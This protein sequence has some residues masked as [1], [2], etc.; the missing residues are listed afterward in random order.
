MMTMKRL[1][2]DKG[3]KMQNYIWNIDTEIID[4]KAKMQYTI[5]GWFVSK[6]KAPFE[7]SACL[8]VSKKELPV[9]VKWVPRDDV[10]SM[11]PFSRENMGPGFVIQL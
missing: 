6:I 9:S 11:Y 8:N 2:M 7:V 3:E 1:F 10:T 5:T 4:Y